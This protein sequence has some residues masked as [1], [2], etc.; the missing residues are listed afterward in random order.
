MLFPGLQIHYYIFMSTSFNGYW[1]I[2]GTTNQYYFLIFRLLCKNG[3]QK[4]I[5]AGTTFEDVES[6]VI[7]ELPTT[8][9]PL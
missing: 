4:T 1:L 8:L 3:M 2:T 6:S 5:K 7:T 9:I